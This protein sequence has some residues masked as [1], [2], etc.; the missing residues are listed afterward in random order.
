MKKCKLCFAEI[1][2]F[3]IIDGKKRNLQRRQFCF[4]C[5]PWGSKNTTNLEKWQ[6]PLSEITK[7]DKKKS[8]YDK[9][10]EY[11]IK[12]QREKRREIKQKL[13]DFL[14]GKCQKCGYNKC[15]ASLEFHH[16]NVN[17]KDFCVSQKGVSIKFDLLLQE[18]S[19]CI[20]LCANC[21]AEEHYEKNENSGKKD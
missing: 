18:V 3:I 15:I 11:V 21:H 16:K 20:L 9:S 2:N 6:R 19:K 13:V 14:G 5:S 10:K 4:I 17:K 12:Y 1:P 8:K 7:E